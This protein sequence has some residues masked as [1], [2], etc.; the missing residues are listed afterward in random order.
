MTD[1][2]CFCFET[3]FGS[4]SL[5]RI[6]RNFCI[7]WILSNTFFVNN[8]FMTYLIAIKVVISA[9]NNKTILNRIIKNVYKKN[10][11]LPHKSKEMRIFPL[12][13]GLTST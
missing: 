12:V 6:G 10:V 8:L 11:H 3:W 9:S 7:Q 2:L 1:Y 5:T 13:T 4:V